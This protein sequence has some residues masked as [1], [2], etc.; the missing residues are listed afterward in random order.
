LHL[1]AREQIWCPGGAH[2]R[3]QRLDIVVTPGNDGRETDRHS[4]TAHR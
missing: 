1:V 3:R 2:L 4:R